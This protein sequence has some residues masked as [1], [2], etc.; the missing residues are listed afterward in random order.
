MTAATQP[1]QPLHQL[2]QA[3]AAA[4][5]DGWS[6]APRPDGEGDLYRVSE[7]RHTDGREINL[8]F[9]D[10]WRKAPARVQVWGGYPEGTEFNGRT[11]RVD[12]SN[13]WNPH[14][15]RPGIS[16][17]ATKT[18]AQIAQDIS[19]RFLPE[20]SRIWVRCKEKADQITAYGQRQLAT[21]AELAVIKGIDLWP[22]RN[23]GIGLEGN[24]SLPGLE[25]YG[26]SV[27]VKGPN[28]IELTLGG[29]TVEQ[30][31]RV[32]DALRTPTDLHTYTTE[33]GRHIHRDGKPFISIQ[34]HGDTSPTDA[35]SLARRLPELLR[36]GQ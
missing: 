7:I 16:C 10:D 34:K 21:R 3:I 5:G 14:E 17:A 11:S 20:Y 26:S 12:Y 31:A 29:L 35:D 13:L 8:E 19:R 24:V 6:Y 1:N 18:P 27:R 28:S 22:D 2:T 4:L 15:E 33:P 23:G 32:L 25:K 36:G 30:V 9:T